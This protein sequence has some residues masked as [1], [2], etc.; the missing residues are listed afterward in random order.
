MKT[1]TITVADPVYA[2]FEAQAQ[3]ANRPAAE[4]IADALGRCVLEGNRPEST[5]SVVD[6]QSFPLG[7]P[8]PPWSSR[9]EMLE[10][11]MDDRG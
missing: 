4:V 2:I 3:R 11:F 1:V 6:I 9:A 8:S 7:P 10:G 5:H